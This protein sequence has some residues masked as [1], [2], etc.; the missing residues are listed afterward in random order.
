MSTPQTKE[1]RARAYDAFNRLLKGPPETIEARPRCPQCDN[2]AHVVGPGNYFC[3]S[4]GSIAVIGVDLAK[5]GAD[6][7]VSVVSFAKDTQQF[8]PAIV[9]GDAGENDN[10]S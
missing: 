5:S 6:R 10:G 3:E 4:C 1:A 8:W 7:S 2:F 9:A